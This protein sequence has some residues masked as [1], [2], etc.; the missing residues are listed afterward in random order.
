MA[1]RVCYVLL[2]K[3][4]S[5][6]VC[7]LKNKRL[8][9][10]QKKIKI[11]QTTSPICRV[12]NRKELGDL[13]ATQLYVTDF[14]P[15]FPV[16]KAMATKPLSELAS[17]VS[18][19][20]V[21]EMDN[22]CALMLSINS[23]HSGVKEY[24]MGRNGAAEKLV[25]R[26]KHG[27]AWCI[28]GNAILVQ[29]DSKLISATEMNHQYLP[30]N[31]ANLKTLQNKFNVA[32][33]EDLSNFMSGKGPAGQLVSA[34]IL[35]SP[36]QPPPPRKGWNLPPSVPPPPPPSGLLQEVQQHEEEE[37]DPLALLPTTGLEE[38]G[39]EE[40]EDRE[41]EEPS[42]EEEVGVSAQVHDHFDIDG[43]TSTEWYEL[44]DG[45]KVYYWSE[46][47]GSTWEAPEWL[48]FD[49]ERGCKK[50]RNTK[51]GEVALQRPFNFVPIRRERQV[52][53][54]N[55]PIGKI[56]D[57]EVD[58]T[59]TPSSSCLV[60]SEEQRVETQKD[61]KDPKNYVDPKMKIYMLTFSK[62]A[63]EYQEQLHNCAELEPLIF[64][65]EQQGYSCT[66]S[67]ASVFVH[68][69]QFQ[70]VRDELQRMSI[71]PH[72]VIVSE[73]YLPL[74]RHAIG[75]ITMQSDIQ[76]DAIP[77]TDCLKVDQCFSCALPAV[78][79]PRHLSKPLWAGDGE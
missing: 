24:C 3:D 14:F 26:Q 7:N 51:T 28:F 33:E 73:T 60:V 10:R 11:T 47:T 52:G 27:Q 68:P 67:Y 43:N 21:Q 6:N 54:D 15:G 31:S 66:Y 48:D 41:D 30:L 55:P 22:H 49:D 77:M 36:S 16:D 62:N 37:D 19:T 76:N 65:S 1:D 38:D 2:T 17:A 32:L 70:P 74:V 75:K 50:Y 4:N 56:Q 40:D 44:R 53:N 61:C 69:S 42:R 59:V 13:L 8:N 79:K 78:L 39:D 45:D 63:P 72:Q 29:Y 57:E 58:T 20:D 23:K 34:R 35:P 9:I 12:S 25:D 5:L 71:F 18:I 46:K 64:F